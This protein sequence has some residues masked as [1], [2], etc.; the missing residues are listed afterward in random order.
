MNTTQSR[1]VEKNAYYQKASGRSEHMMKT[2]PFKILFFQIKIP[3][4]EPMMVTD[5]SSITTFCFLRHGL[6]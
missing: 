5:S 6:F 2:Q 3:K 4:N 1:V